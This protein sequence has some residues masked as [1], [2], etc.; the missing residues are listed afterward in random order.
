[1][2]AVIEKNILINIEADSSGEV[3][4]RLTDLL[5]KNGCVKI[6]YADVVISREEQYPTGIPAA[7]L[8]VAIPHGFADECVLE[9]SVGVATLARPVMFGNMF[10]PDEEL[11]VR[12]VFL[13]ALSSK[14]KNELAKDLERVMSILPDG[15]LLAGLYAAE[16]GREFTEL[17]GNRLGKTL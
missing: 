9:P 2:L 14:D 3:I 16:S 11:A 4:R 10:N 13:I 7:G 15:D 8:S 6:E 1:M 17:L 12:M 5:V